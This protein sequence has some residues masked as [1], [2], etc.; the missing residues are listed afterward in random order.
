[1]PRFWRVILISLVIVLLLY[2]IYFA[3]GRPVIPLPTIPYKVS[4]GQPLHAIVTSDG[5]DQ[6]K[7]TLNTSGVVEITSSDQSVVALNYTPDTFENTLDLGERL[8]IAQRIVQ[9][10][11]DIPESSSFSRKLINWVIAYYYHVIRF[12]LSV[13]V[14]ALP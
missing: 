11:G 8:L 13:L 1:M 3:L 10:D 2:G 14:T 12:Q 7:L 4:P 9:G 6:L 5:A